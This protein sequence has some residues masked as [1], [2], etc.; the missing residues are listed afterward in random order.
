MK[1]I[2]IIL[3]ISICAGV[4]Q[5][6]DTLSINSELFTNAHM[7]TV[8]QNRQTGILHSPIDAVTEITA[9]ENTTMRLLHR[10]YGDALWSENSIIEYI[11][12]EYGLS[13]SSSD[14]EIVRATSLFN[15]DYR[16]QDNGR[17]PGEVWQINTTLWSYWSFYSTHCG[18]HRNRTATMIQGITDYLSVSPIHCEY[19]SL[20]GHQ[21][22]QYFDKEYQKWIFVDPD[23]G[24]GILFI[25]DGQNHFASIGEIFANPE[26]I[27]N[28]E[29]V[30]APLS[31]TSHAYEDE[32]INYYENMIEIFSEGPIET[33]E[34]N[35]IFD[36]REIY[37]NVPSGVK[38]EIPHTD[39]KKMMILRLEGLDTS[40]ILSGIE[41]M[42]NGDEV[43]WWNFVEIAANHNNIDY[44][45]LV[46]YFY[47]YDVHVT[48][49][50]NLMDDDSDIKELYYNFE[51]DDYI[52]IIV[53]PGEYNESM[54]IP[55]ALRSIEPSNPN[56]S[57]IWNNTEYTDSVY[58]PMYL[59]TLSV[60]T[61]LTTTSD[62]I[63][64]CTQLSIPESLGP[65][66]LTFYFNRKLFNGFD[67]EQKLIVES[68]SVNINNLIK[69]YSEDSTNQESEPLSLSQNDVSG[70]KVYPNPAHQTLF[71]SK[72]AHMKLHSIDGKMVAEKY[73][74]SLDVSYLSKGI[75][76]L[77][78]HEDNEIFTSHKVIV[79]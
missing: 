24:N 61:S 44:N 65:L 8:L 46:S 53:P 2:F 60:D 25:S 51:G 58:I 77:H 13:A 36:S 41:A 72:E 3:L 6:Q 19:I 52:T 7:H 79:N 38:L 30:V 47:S 17:E 34:I 48:I 54:Y 21:V 28:S 40:I 29:T 66:K 63:Q 1:K 78:I 68:G 32:R 57:Y 55:L 69:G 50:F 31:N 35:Y 5:A 23:P 74:T 14:Y 10:D 56:I 62:M 75:Y 4:I 9:L 33:G 27:L 45:D 76:I 18:E 39:N 43:G 37:F 49:D 64:E 20:E 73:G 70:I 12:N 59:P 67:G 71:I 15:K 16:L 11:I 42:E 22:L 26:L